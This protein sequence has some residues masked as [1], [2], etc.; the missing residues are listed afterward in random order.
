[1]YSIPYDSI[2]I[3]STENAGILDINSEVCLWT[4]LGNFK[5]KLSKG[6]DVRNFDKLI[7][8]YVLR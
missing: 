2:L 4:K 8:S 3:W 1:M 6:V 7:A 5:I